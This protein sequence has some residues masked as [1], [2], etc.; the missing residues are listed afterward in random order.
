MTTSGSEPLASLEP[1]VIGATGGSGTRVVARIV[2][3]GGLFIGT[4]LNRYEDA[5][6]FAAYFDRWINP[7]VAAVD[8]GA[9]TALFDEMTRELA[10]VVGTHLRER[11]GDAGLWGWKEPRSIYL[12][13]FF[14]RLMSGFHFLH[15]IRDGRDMAFSENQNQLKK[16]GRVVLPRSRLPFRSR[17][18]RSIELW[19]RVNTLAADYGE[20]RM[21]GRY[22]RVQFERLCAEPGPTIEGILR[23]FGL[24][25]D[26]A[27]IA[28]EEVSPPATLGRWRDRGRRTI[29]ELDRIAGPAL[30]R[31]GYSS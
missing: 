3:E 5:L 26:A 12:L 24:R 25:G 9:R 19:A 28:A 6:D 10:E 22:F 14:D 15:V 11:P 4:N 23:F 17:P 18:S 30:A 7:Y 13:P 27:R 20:Q 8:E 29:A 2:R 1:R 31:F 21:A 16:H